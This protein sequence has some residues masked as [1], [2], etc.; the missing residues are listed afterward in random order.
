MMGKKAARWLLGAALGIVA[1]LVLNLGGGALFTALHIEWAWTIVVVAGAACLL[2]AVVM[3]IVAA[4][5][6]FRAAW[7]R[8]AAG[9]Q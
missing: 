6:G 3:L 7:R 2:A 4:V 5:L 1:F 8:T 9:D